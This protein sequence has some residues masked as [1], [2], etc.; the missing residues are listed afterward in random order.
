M[1]YGVTDNGF[2]LKR[3]DAIIEEIHEDLTNGF[4]YNTRVM[5]PSFLDTLVTTFAGQIA[6][7]WE[8]AQNNYYSKFVS[9]AT[10]K[11]LDNAAQF[12][13]LQRAAR[14]QSVYPLY[15]TGDDGTT[16]PSGAVVATGTLPEIRLEAVS[17]IQ[18]SRSSFN[19]AIIRAAAVE[20]AGYTVTLNGEDYTYQATENDTEKTIIDGLITKLNDNDFSA[21]KG[22]DGIAIK[23]LAS[24]KNNTLALSENLT[25]VSVTS[26]GQFATENYGKVVIPNGLVTKIVQNVPGFN[27]VTNQL[28]ASYGRDEETD[29]EF[30]QSYLAK[31]AMRSNS[32]V[33][34]IADAIS[35]E[36]DGVE[37]AVGYENPEDVTDSYGLP[38]HSIELVVEGGDSEEIAAII[39]EKKVG[40]ILTYGSVQTNVVGGN[41]ETILISFNRPTYLYVWMKV[42]VH[43]D[44]SNLPLNYKTIISDSIIDDVGNLKAGESILIQTL[45]SGIYAGVNGL[46]YVDVAVACSLDKNSTPS[47]SDYK[48]QNVI[49]TSRQMIKVATSRIEVSFDGDS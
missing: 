4:G 35:E 34:A 28:S 36:V 29:I 2:V 46:S 27:S 3:M 14:K 12:G 20:A 9:T 22:E 48:N 38:P 25:T 31:S 44:K 26:I 8:T 18:I 37:S 11:N 45:A 23:C 17:D 24:T 7:L 49:V 6:D 32:M 39:L 16:I 1:A 47:E 33:D 43:G 10:G 30:R 19:S 5:R 21:E 15:C 41:G 40:G 13:G 42:T